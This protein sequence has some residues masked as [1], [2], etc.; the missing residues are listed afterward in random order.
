MFTDLSF[1]SQWRTSWPYDSNAKD[2]AYR[3]EPVDL[4]NEPDR[5][6]ELPE[7]ERAPGL[8]PFL[9]LLNG[10]SSIFRTLACNYREGCGE[11]LGHGVG[12]YV[13][14]AFKENASCQHCDPYVIVFGRLSQILHETFPGIDFETAVSASMERFDIYGTEAGWTMCLDVHVFRP[15][16]DE[17]RKDWISLLDVI[18]RHLVRMKLPKLSGRNLF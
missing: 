4:R 14:L 3:H 2:P 16:L 13:Y 8:A 17:A 9:Q 7:V 1:D 15:D 10:K 12:S 6:Y 5:V 11:K 18:G